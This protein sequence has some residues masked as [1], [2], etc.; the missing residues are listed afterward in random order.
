MAQ[1][2]GSSR[3]LVAAAPVTGEQSVSGRRRE[4]QSSEHSEGGEICV[5]ICVDNLDRTGDYQVKYSPQW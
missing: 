4:E 3:P 5:D 1:A 2:G